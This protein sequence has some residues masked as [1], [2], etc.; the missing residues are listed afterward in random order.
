[1]TLE[2]QWEVRAGE[3]REG[4]G[5]GKG[6]VEKVRDIESKIKKSLRRYWPSN[7]EVNGAVGEGEGEGEG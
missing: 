1:M 2:A 3:R 5:V 4:K 7:G 6:K